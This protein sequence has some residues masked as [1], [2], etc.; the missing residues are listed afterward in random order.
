MGKR[1]LVCGA[2]SGIGRATALAL[3]T[4]GAQVIALARREDRLVGITDEINSRFPGEAGYVVADLDDRLALR[5][6]IDSILAEGG[7]VHIL[8]NNTGGPPP[9]QL[10]DATAEDLQT[11]FSRHVLAAHLLITAFLP[12]MRESG[13]GRIVNIISTSVREPIPGLGVSNTIR[14]AMAGFSKTISNELPGGVT[15]NN[16]LPGYTDTERLGSLC[17]SIANR[18]GKTLEEVRAGWVAK[19]PEGRLGAPE[20]VA[21]AVAFLAGPDAGY[22]RGQSLAV[23]GG[24]MK[25][26]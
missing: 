4:K 11:A 7:P 22:I 21:A 19:V 1:A 13:F 25:S 20:E 2:S 9:G 16:V 8:V 26:I 24:R 14:A 17:E 6:I 5:G 12:G 10:L 23:D 3:A 15:I 18:T